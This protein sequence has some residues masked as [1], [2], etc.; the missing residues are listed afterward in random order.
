MENKDPGYMPG[1][2][3]HK[4][5]LWADNIA[6]PYQSPRLCPQPFCKINFMKSK[7]ASSSEV[8]SLP[9]VNTAFVRTKGILYLGTALV[10]DLQ[11]IVSIDT[12]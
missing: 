5:L 2:L 1:A 6:D 4:T 7:L 10:L 12:C 9:V 3:E 8:Q 11:R